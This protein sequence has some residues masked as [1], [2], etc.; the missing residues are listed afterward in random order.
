MK[1]TVRILEGARERLARPGGW[2]RYSMAGK[3]ISPFASVFV[4]T[5]SPEA[6]CFCAYGACL[7]AAGIDN[8][9]AGFIAKDA[10]D[11]EWARCLVDALPAGPWREDSLFETIANYND[12]FESSQEAV[13]EW[14]DRAIALA[15]DLETRA[16][17]AEAGSRGKEVRA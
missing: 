5:L 13:I 16:Q 9:S 14:F 8:N 12:R 4:S 1:A 15:R 6:N 2:M 7:A 10:P 17:G 3:D 11:W